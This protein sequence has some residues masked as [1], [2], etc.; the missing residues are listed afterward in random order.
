VLRN[1]P[2]LPTETTALAVDWRTP[3]RE[4][5]LS[6]GMVHVWRAGLD[7]ET[8]CLRHLERYL[9]VDERMRAARFRFAQ[10]RERFVAA[11][12]MLREILSLYL[13]MEARRLS[14]GYRTNGKPFLANQ[15]D[16]AL[17]FNV[18]HSL[19][20]VLIAVAH[21]RK[22]GVDIEC[23]RGGI[24]VEE[25]AETV[26]SASERQVLS[27]LRSEAKHMA[28]LRLWT[29]KEA[30]IKADGRGVSLPLKHIDVSA[31]TDRVARLDEATGEWRVLADWRLRT[32]SVGPD[33][34]ASLAAEDQGWEL[35]FWRWC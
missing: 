23:A 22:V 4:L 35:A 16:G 24:A 32:L 14:F 10:D 7:L 12:G 19:D 33:H 20:T 15:D 8:A 2:A 17:C 9:S 31:P 3:P 18:S 27:S 13:N 29:R 25:I 34:A 11:R 1:G 21:K 26:F 28:F 30:Y 5:A 6:T